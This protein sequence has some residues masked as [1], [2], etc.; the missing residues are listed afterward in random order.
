VTRAR[1]SPMIP[2]LTEECACAILLAHACRQYQSVLQARS[3]AGVTVPRYE[4]LSDGI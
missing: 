3:H 2:V 4:T 1:V